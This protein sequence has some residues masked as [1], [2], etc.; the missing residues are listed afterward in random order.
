MLRRDKSPPEHVL[1]FNRIGIQGMFCR[2]FV[3]FIAL[4]GLIQSAYAITVTDIAA[5]KITL[6]KPAQK[7][8]LG[9]GR[10]IA[11]IGILDRKDPTGRVVGML[12]EFKQFDP[13][14]FM[15]YS[16]HFPAI[17]DIPL[18][19]F[20]SETSVSIEKAIS[21][22]P[23]V[24]I[25][26]MSGHGPSAKSK[27]LTDKLEAAGI[28]IIFI[29]FR[30]N[31]IINTPK[32]M[33]ILGQ[34]LGREKE[35]A[36]YIEFYNSQLARVS[37]PLKNTKIKKPKVFL[38]TH[39]GLSNVCCRTISKAMLSRFIEFA[40]GKNIADGVVPGIAGTVNLEFVISQQ[41]DVYIGTAIGSM[42]TVKKAPNRI[43]LGVGAT[44]EAARK[45]FRNALSRNG[46]SGLKAIK[47]K[48]AHSIWH[49][50]YNSPLNIIAIQAF[51][52]W[53][54]PQLYKELSPEDT[55]KTLYKKFQPVPL[56]G[57]YMISAD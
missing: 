25:F 36:E 49:H 18:F 45:S 2:I 14:G 28:K 56:S 39:I 54:H 43:V 33:K 23:E 40:G 16:K 1:L 52:K 57:K 26:G 41:P 35:A 51:A 48:R 24:A 4:T 50:Y 34:V 5:R 29:D 7:I 8:I 22:K 9:E 47:T 13:A 19:G 6:D 55:L 44:E 31:P 21:L 15:Y 11:A 17:R 37:T 46:I 38:E 30:D 32:S 27:A 20:T 10:F 12:G 3:F 42:L 53:I